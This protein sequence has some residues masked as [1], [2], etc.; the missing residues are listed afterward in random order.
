MR[1]LRLGSPPVA[2]SGRGRRSERTERVRKGRWKRVLR[3][4]APVKPPAA[5][6]AVESE[7][8][9]AEKRLNVRRPFGYREHTVRR[10][11]RPPGAL[12]VAVCLGTL[13]SIILVPATV[14]LVGTGPHL[15]SG[16]T[17][18]SGAS[19]V[20]VFPAAFGLA[21]GADAP[22]A[23]IAVSLSESSTNVQVGSA[24]TFQLNI[25][26]VG[27]TVF[28]MSSLGELTIALG[29]GTA[30]QQSGNTGG[31]GS[32]LSCVPPPD[33]NDTSDLVDFHYVY[34]NS[35]TY[36]V[37]VQ[38]NWT[39]GSPLRTNSVTV[40]VSG[41]PMDFVVDGWFYGVVG[42]VGGA[43]LL[44]AIFR[45]RLPKPPSLPPGAA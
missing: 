7:E 21:R 5:S 18:P 14:P 24:V 34:A 33:P 31:P 8:I 29:D 11:E 36:T 32:A 43:L 28:Y 39:G 17:D 42:T 35:G 26:L 4:F 38:V 20:R 41:S 2:P 25:S 13:L 16:N 1:L 10:P 19:A 30:L 37:S 23:P 45:R 44:V 15:G 12:I 27:C 40:D 9:A 6:K 3:R 22:S